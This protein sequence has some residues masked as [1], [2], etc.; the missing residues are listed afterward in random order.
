[1]Q[2]HLPESYK[3]ALALLENRTGRSFLQQGGRVQAVRNLML[4]QPDVTHQ[5]R[6]YINML[7]DHEF[8]HEAIA[9][10]AMNDAHTRALVRDGGRRS[11]TVAALGRYGDQLVLLPEGHRR[12]RAR[13]ADDGPDG[14][15]AVKRC[16][17]KKRLASCGREG[18]RLA[19]PL[20][21]LNDATIL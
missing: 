6:C 18:G 10:K 8:A 13:D 12:A 17:A 20:T 11:H 21:D 15:A 4:R 19:S 5:L 1:M 14:R 16:R 3:T 7:L 9:H 2:S